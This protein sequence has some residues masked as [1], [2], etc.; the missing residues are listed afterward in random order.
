[1]ATLRERAYDANQYAHGTLIEAAEAIER[2]D[3]T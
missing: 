3:L 1:M 2:G